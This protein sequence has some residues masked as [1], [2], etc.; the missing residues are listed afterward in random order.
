MSVPRLVLGVPQVAITV[1]DVA[2]GV[3]FYQE[4]LGFEL[5]FKTP[6]MAMLSC[7]ETR[8]LLG[9]DSAS[10]AGQAVFLYFRVGDIR[11][12]EAVLKE[13]GVRIDGEP[14]VVGQFQG[15]DVWLATFRDDD[16]TLHHLISEVPSLR[17]PVVASV[18]R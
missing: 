12:A 3:V 7:G 8:L 13:R 15:K 5:L 1:R 18:Q 2:A 16:G 11:A 4:K 9:T 6:Q 17:D 10:S 14:H